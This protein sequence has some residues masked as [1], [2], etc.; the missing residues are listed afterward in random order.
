MVDEYTVRFHLVKGAG[1]QLPSTFATNVG[2][3]VSPEAFDDPSVDLA[4]DPGN[5]GSGPYIVTSYVPTESMT[6]ER[7]PSYW[8]PEVG[9]L[10]GSRSSGCRTAVPGCG[11]SRPD[12]PT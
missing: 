1:V 4:N 2:M 8:D 6:V 5:A 12:R 10:A 3:M 11:V 7:A 9:R